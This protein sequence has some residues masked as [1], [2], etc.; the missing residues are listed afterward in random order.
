MSRLNRIRAMKPAPTI[1]GVKVI[2]ASRYPM[3]S[4]KIRSI[5]SMF[6]VMGNPLILSQNCYLSPLGYSTNVNVSGFHIISELTGG[7]SDKLIWYYRLC[8]I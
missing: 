1:N 2:H 6:Q 7:P 3:I 5:E 4:P 8:K